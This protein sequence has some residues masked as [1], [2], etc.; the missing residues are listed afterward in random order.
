MLELL[1]K[2]LGVPLNSP[3]LAAPQHIPY[4][5]FLLPWPSNEMRVSSVSKGQQLCSLVCV[6]AISLAGKTLA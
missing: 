6:T 4:F 3:I 5:Y 1:V 2:Y